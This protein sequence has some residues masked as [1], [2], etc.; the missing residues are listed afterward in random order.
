MDL[1]GWKTGSRGEHFGGDL[2]QLRVTLPVILVLPILQPGLRDIVRVGKA[3]MSGCITPKDSTMTDRNISADSVPRMES[4]YPTGRM[5]SSVDGR[6]AMPAPV[7]DVRDYCE[8]MGE[9][10]DDFESDVGANYK[11][12]YEVQEIDTASERKMSPLTLLQSGCFLTD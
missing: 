5:P 1:F 9:D 12:S 7:R 4:R 6:I 11:L 2:P 3:V 8:S 10:L